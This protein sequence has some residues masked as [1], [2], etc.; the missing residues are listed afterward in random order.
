M[1]FIDVFYA[2]AL[3][4][5]LVWLVLGSVID[6]RLPGS[7]LADENAASSLPA[8][9]ALSSPPQPVATA[10]VDERSFWIFVAGNPTV[11]SVAIS[12]DDNAVSREPSSDPLDR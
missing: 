4:V 9:G 10:T 1:R 3:A 12:E 8:V 2:A 11:W 5:L 6:A 7:L